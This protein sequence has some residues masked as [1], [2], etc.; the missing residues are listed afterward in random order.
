LNLR[1]Y[2]L[3]QLN[4]FFR[5]LIKGFMILDSRNSCLQMHT[6]NMVLKKNFGGTTAFIPDKMIPK[7][8]CSVTTFHKKTMHILAPF[9]LFLFCVCTHLF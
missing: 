7:S 5:I 3:N 8:Y 2:A 4:V 6:N 1:D 9:F